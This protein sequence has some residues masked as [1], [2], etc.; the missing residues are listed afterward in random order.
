MRR[1]LET[2]QPITVATILRAAA[3]HEQLEA[4]CICVD[5]I[6]SSANTEVNAQGNLTLEA[7]GNTTL[8]GA[9]VNIN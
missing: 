1:V 2:R 5:E 7:S 3:G 4:Q 9:M 8:K 6:R